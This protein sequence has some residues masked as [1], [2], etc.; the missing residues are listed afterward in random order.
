MDG[1]MKDGW[2]KD[3]G[4]MDGGMKDGWME[5]EGCK[6]EWGGWTG[7]QTSSALAS[8]SGRGHSEWTEA[9][10]AMK[11]ELL[12]PHTAHRLWESPT[13]CPLPSPGA[14]SWYKSHMSGPVAKGDAQIGGQPRAGAKSHT[15]GSGVMRHRSEHNP[16][17]RYLQ[18][19]AHMVL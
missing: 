8:A 11:H 17:S 12:C 3:E 13:G 10:A 15:L 18:P 2:M 9:P 1:G 4:W 5:D 16:V 19:V 7:G 6:E 14:K